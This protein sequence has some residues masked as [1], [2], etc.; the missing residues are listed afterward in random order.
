MVLFDC[1]G[2]LVDSE[3]L[4]T[5]VLCNNLK[6][7]GLTLRPSQFASL[8]LGGTIFGIA[9]RARAMG[10]RLPPSWAEDVYQEVFDVLAD[11]VEPIRGIHAV[12]DALDA[13]GIGYAIG[14]NGP[15]RKMEITLGRTGL[16]PRFKGRVYSRE[17]VPHPKPAPDVYL[18]AAADADVP[19]SRCCVIEDSPSGARA[20]QV[21]GMYCLGFAAET[22]VARLQ[23]VC[24]DVFHKMAELPEILGL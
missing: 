17:D 15:H 10:A 3:T 21:A 19:P 18:K 20:G 8:F 24:D 9:E 2:V 12:L 13:A 1:D 16:M 23:P 6:R 14:S 11:H 22:P 5:Q 7:H 4:T